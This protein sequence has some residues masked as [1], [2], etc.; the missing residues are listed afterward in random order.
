MAR[1]LVQ[2]PNAQGQS[3]ALPFGGPSTPQLNGAVNPPVMQQPQ[4]PPQQQPQQQAG[5]QQ[6]VANAA[7]SNP[8]VMPFPQPNMQSN[9]GMMGSSGGMGMMNSD[10]KQ[11]LAMQALRPGSNMSSMTPNM[12]PSGMVPVDNLNPS[13]AG[14]SYPQPN[15]MMDYSGF[16]SNNMSATLMPNGAPVLIRKQDGWN[17]VGS[18]TMVPVSRL[19]TPNDLASWLS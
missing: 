2:R 10:V 7:V 9:L 11:D 6:N 12:Q 5:L 15:N 19:A 13:L 14:N 17:S 4:Q 18:P 16:N 3:P 8:Q 1:R